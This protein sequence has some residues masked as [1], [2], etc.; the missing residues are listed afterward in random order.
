[1]FLHVIIQAIRGVSK[2]AVEA[3]SCAAIAAGEAA[4]AEQNLASLHPDERDKAPLLKVRLL[5]FPSPVQSLLIMLHTN[6]DLWLL[7]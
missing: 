7:V 5:S 2:D 3:S 1:M 6:H 4:E